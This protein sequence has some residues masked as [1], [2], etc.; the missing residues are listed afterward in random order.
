MAGHGYKASR[1]DH[2]VQIAIEVEDPGHTFEEPV[3]IAAGVGQHADTASQSRHMAA[4][5][6]ASSRQSFADDQIGIAENPSIRSKQLTSPPATDSTCRLTSRN[7][8]LV[9]LT[10]KRWPRATSGS[11]KMMGIQR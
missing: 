1:L 5:Q 3:I 4:R 9:V 7:R 8:C 2:E 6:N 10:A 11:G